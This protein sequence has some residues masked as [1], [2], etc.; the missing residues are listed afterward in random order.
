M[1]TVGKMSSIGL[2]C[3]LLSSNPHPFVII[4]VG[5]ISQTSALCRSTIR[6]KVTNDSLAHVFMMSGL[7]RI[8]PVYTCPTLSINCSSLTAESVLI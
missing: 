6:F 4:G 1:Y 7:P 5:I 2:I 3:S 8:S